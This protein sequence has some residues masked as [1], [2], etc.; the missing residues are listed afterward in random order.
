MSNLIKPIYMVGDHHGRWDSL[1]RTIDHVGIGNCYLIHVGDGG[2]GFLAPDKQMRQFEHCNNFF[3]SRNISYLSIRGNHSDPA[4]FNG[5]HRIRMG[6]FE[7]LPDYETKELNGEKF[8]F[9][10]GAISIDRLYRVPGQSYWHD[11]AFVLKPELVTECDV[12]VTHS[13]P[14]WNGPMDK[15]GLSGWCEKD[16]LL[17]DECLKERKDHDELIRLAKP[18][19][20]YCGHFHA[21][22]WVEMNGCYSTILAI[23]QVKEH[24]LIE[25]AF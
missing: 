7:L 15:D 22:H 1:F 14:S 5:E 3:K 19:M 12:L 4:Y 13:G 24:K 10:G 20:H 16:P 11:E 21:Y 18:K 6:N 25:S 23:E 17:W 2:E 9:V 8:L